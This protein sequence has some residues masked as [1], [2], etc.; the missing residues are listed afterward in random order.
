MNIDFTKIDKS[1]FECI[2]MD[3]S[4]AVYFGQLQYMH[5]ETGE[6]L[7]GLDDIEEEEQKQL[8]K[9]VRHGCGI[10]LFGKN[11]Q[12][13]TCKYAGEWDRDEKTG[14]G[15][16]IY[17]D[18]SEYR[19][20]FVKGVFQGRGLFWWPPAKSGN[21]AS[22]NRHHYNGVWVDGKMHGK[23]E[24][25]HADTGEVSKGYFANNLY[26]YASKGQKH[27]LNPFDSL[28]QQKKFLEKARES[29][30]YNKKVAEEKE[31]TIKLH[32]VAS[33]N[34]LN[35][36]LA[37]TKASGRTPLILT[38]PQSQL[39]NQ[40][41]AEALECEGSG[42]SITQLHLRN[43]ALEVQAVPYDERHAYLDAKY[44]FEERLLNQNMIGNQTGQ[45]LLN[46]DEIQ[47]DESN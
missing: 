39:R 14:D 15:H 25:R 3:D 27:F 12:G 38:S 8:Y 9:R 42:R 6:L 19:G 40:D 7:K 44:A 37:K 13:V 10:Q 36:A 24:F 46:F 4:G 34:E 43:L 21:P 31:Q 35:E 23:G 33:L 28:D 1:D 5:T 16:Q 2:Q 11:D 41:V 26:A 22:G 32:R 18:G 30:V 47:A 29:V 20:N 17:P 45:I